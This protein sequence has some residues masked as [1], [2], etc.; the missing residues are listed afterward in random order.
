MGTFE[1]SRSPVKTYHEVFCTG[2][3]S[4]YDNLIAQT[5]FMYISTHCRTVGVKT[6]V[7]TC[8]LDTYDDESE[9]FGDGI[10][11]SV[12]ILTLVWIYYDRGQ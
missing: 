9:A 11:A 10:D 3:V 1:H 12:G 5:V 2:P 7:K 6:C 4:I 8:K